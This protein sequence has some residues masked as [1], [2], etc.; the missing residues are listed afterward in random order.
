MDNSFAKW[1]RLIEGLSG[2]LRLVMPSLPLGFGLSSKGTS[3]RPLKSQRLLRVPLEMVAYPCQS[4]PRPNPLPETPSIVN[5]EHCIHGSLPL[6]SLVR[7]FTL[8]GP[9]TFS[10]LPLL[11]PS[12]R[13]LPFHTLSAIGWTSSSQSGL[14]TMA[15]SGY[16]DAWDAGTLL[17]L[18]ALRK[19]PRTAAFLALTSLPTSLGCRWRKMPSASSGH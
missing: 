9:W 15:P 3:K 19:M 4:L 5:K 6:S 17:T 12:L 8:K 7:S 2:L 18:S 10:N 14:C 11:L 1:S 16:V 13:G